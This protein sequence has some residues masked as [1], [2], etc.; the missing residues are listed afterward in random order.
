M[1]TMELHWDFLHCCCNGLTTCFQSDQTAWI[2][3]RLHSQ[4]LRRST[5]QHF[6]CFQSDLTAWMTVR[7]KQTVIHSQTCTFQHLTKVWPEIPFPHNPTATYHRVIRRVKTRGG[8]Y[9]IF[10][11]NEYFHWMNNHIF[12][13]WIN[14]LNEFVGAIEWI[15]SWMNIFA[16]LL[17]EFLNESKKC[18]IH[19]KNE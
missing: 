13:E 16:V 6:T 3:V 17:N 19:K 10:Q 11:K 14:S 7:F 1:L 4:T 8:Q 15:N 18:D 9:G 2:T 12:F 5:F